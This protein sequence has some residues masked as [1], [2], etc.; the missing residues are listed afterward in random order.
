M[1]EEKLHSP[2]VD[3]YQFPFVL[4]PIINTFFSPLS[5]FLRKGALPL[6]VSCLGWEGLLY[7]SRFFQVPPGFA[8]RRPRGL[9]PGGF[10]DPAPY[11]PGA[12]PHAACVR[13]AAVS[14]AAK[15]AGGSWAA[16]PGFSPAPRAVSH[17]DRLRRAVLTW[18]QWSLQSF[19]L[20]RTRPRL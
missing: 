9:T 20:L 11:V 8:V 3:K 5:F 19:P 12:A 16:A 14:A 6:R 17:V 10:A 13:A 1:E 7:G 15:R 4:L 2:G 18:F